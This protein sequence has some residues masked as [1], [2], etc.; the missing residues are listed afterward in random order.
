MRALISILFT[1]AFIW[2]VSWFFNKL[3]NKYLEISDH[4]TDQIGKYVVYEQD[5]LIVI[6]SSSWDATFTLSDGTIIG[7][8]LFEQLEIVDEN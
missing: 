8:K 4:Y 2:A 7:N 5:T 6:D 3:G 1:I